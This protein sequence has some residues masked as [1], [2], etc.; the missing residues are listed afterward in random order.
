MIYEKDLSNKGTLISNNENNENKD[1]KI[2][3][4]KNKDISNIIRAY[5]QLLLTQENQPD[6][7]LNNRNPINL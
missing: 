3:E 1:T 5:N 2:I 6:N 4:E 7:Y